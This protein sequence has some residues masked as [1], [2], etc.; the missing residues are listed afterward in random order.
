MEKQKSKF[1]KTTKNLVWILVFILFGFQIGIY[2]AQK[3][4]VV[5]DLAKDEVVYLGK[6]TGKYSEA[7]KDILTQDVDFKLFWEVWDELKKEY[8]D[9]GELNDKELFYGAI[10]GMVAA[11]GD[12][13]TTYMD[14][15]ITQEF[16]D[17]LEGK[18]EGIGAEIS[19]KDDVLTVVSPLEGSPAENA[20]LK[21]GDKI[22]SID[23]ETT[24]GLSID[25]AVKKIRGPKGEKVT[26]KIARE[27]L[28]EFKNIEII[29]DVIVIK[30]IKTEY[31]DDGIFVVEILNFNGDT[32]E[33]FDKAIR[34][35][36][37]KNPK[38][39]ILDLRNNPGGLLDT[40]IEIAS[41]W[42]ED[43]VV[44]SEADSQGEKS[45]FYARGRARLKDYKTVVLVNEG[46]AS[47]SEI[48]AGA[49]KSHNKAIIIGK[50]TFGK[51]SVQTLSDF[52]DGS[53][54]KVTIAKWL[55]PDGISISEEGISPDEEV[56]YTL[57]DY[58][59]DI[60]PQMDR[61]VEIINDSKS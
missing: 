49:L 19:I 56:D 27:G 25:E 26:L 6:L 33:L 39:I 55:T 51:G 60:D 29:R 34:E 35:I 14:P 38:G 20:G 24:T 1:K 3:N 15:K 17:D 11:A 61:A 7:N 36:L 30:S 31:R 4:E 42:I 53:S 5:K 13:Y 46:S 9:S 54:L 22:I 52:S 50:T 32:M 12:P 47:A 40:S 21:A 23:D 18:F 44:V 45:D 57:E 16:N 2:S 8:V 41:E 10:R 58:E 37:A 48:V 59:A 28:D 43:G